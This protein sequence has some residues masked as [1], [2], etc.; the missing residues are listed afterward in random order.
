M[1]KHRFFRVVKRTDTPG[2]DYHITEQ[3]P[4][5]SHQTVAKSTNRRKANMSAG[6]RDSE[7]TK[8]P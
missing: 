4:N 5:G 1:A 2:P 8:K 3:Q 7:R 6:I